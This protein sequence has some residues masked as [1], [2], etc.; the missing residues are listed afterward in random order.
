MSLYIDGRFMDICGI[1]YSDCAMQHCPTQ[2][3]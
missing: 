2:T 3:E 1:T